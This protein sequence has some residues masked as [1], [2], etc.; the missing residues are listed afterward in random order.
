M[1]AQF[2]AAAIAIASLF[3]GTTISQA[4]DNPSEKYL[5]AHKEYSAA[6]CPLEADNITHFVYFARDR[7]SIRDHPL[8]KNDRLS[9]AQIMYS[10]R[11][12]EPSQGRYDFSAIEDDLVYLAAH[13]K[14]LFVQLQDASFSPHFKPVPNYLLSSRYDGGVSPQYTDDGELEGWV[15]KRWNN[16][17]QGRFAALLKALGE[18]FDGEIE[19]LNLQETAIGISSE[20]DPSF[21]SSIYAS[22]VKTNMRAL[23]SAFRTSTVMLYANFMPG[24]WRPWE[25]QGY[26]SGLYEFGEETGVGLGAPDLIYTRKGQLNHA[27]AMMHERSYSAPLGIAV[28][29][30]NYIGETNT[31]K[32]LHERKNIV[33][34]LHAFAKDFLK[35]DYMFWRNQK[36]YFEE[37]L[38][39]CL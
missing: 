1:N 10:W 7:A 35:V 5:N 18:E 8:L 23:K 4:S 11:Q 25:D 17:V 39:P 13:G 21:S 19:G 3:I 27:L 33:P 20:T 6:S 15:A 34:V 37:D 16:S 12:L 30:G 14:K 24:E 32:V 9:G 36:P 22:S 31:L 26:L 2:S 38:L 29:D 28:Q